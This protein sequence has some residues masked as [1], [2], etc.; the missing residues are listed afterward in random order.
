MDTIEN[1]DGAFDILNIAE[2]CKHESS[3]SREVKSVRIWSVLIRIVF[4]MLLEPQSLVIPLRN[5]THN[6]YFFGCF[7]IF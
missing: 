6:I 4:G 7:A 1:S 2:S 5:K 3:V